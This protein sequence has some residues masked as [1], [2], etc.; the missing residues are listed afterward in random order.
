[1]IFLHYQNLSETKTCLICKFCILIPFYS[2]RTQYH[3]VCGRFH[4]ELFQIPRSE[5]ESELVPASSSG[6][7]FCLLFAM[8]TSMP[9]F[10]LVYKR[11]NDVAAS[12]CQTCTFY[13]EISYM[14]VVCFLM[15]CQQALQF[16]KNNIWTT[17]EHCSIKAK[18]TGFTIFRSSWKL[19]KPFT[20]TQNMNYCYD[21]SLN[22]F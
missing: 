1:M 11:S 12:G 4:V 16:S 15:F 10:F 14:I 3:S 22:V 18:M 8:R 20:F 5:R 2:I 19:N 9:S 21:R 6:P 13:A 17:K 7:P